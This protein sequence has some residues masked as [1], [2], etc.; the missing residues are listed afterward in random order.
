[1]KFQ[2]MSK[3]MDDG[4][5][6]QWQNSA[7]PVLSY[8]KLTV[9]NHCCFLPISSP[10]LLWIYRWNHTIQIKHSYVM[11]PR[12]FPKEACCLQ[13]YFCKSAGVGAHRH[14][15]P[16]SMWVNKS[17]MSLQFS[18]MNRNWV[19]INQTLWIA[20]ASKFKSDNWVAQCIVIALLCENIN[21]KVSSEYVMCLHHSWSR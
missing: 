13:F 10:S 14:E 20:L 7:Q 16:L 9:S 19:K 8:L 18:S 21:N 5:S 6:A 15:F 2:F 1:M 4:L 12:R 11:L 3:P 17:L